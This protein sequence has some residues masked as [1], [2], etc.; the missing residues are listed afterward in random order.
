MVKFITLVGHKG[1]IPA[2]FGDQPMPNPADFG[3][4]AEDDGSRNDPLLGQN[5]IANSH[6]EH[7]FDALRAAA[8]RI[9]LAAGEESTGEMVCRAAL[10][11]AERL[12]IA[13]VIF[14]SNHGGFLGGEYGMQGDRTR[15]PP[16]CARFSPTPAATTDR[17]RTGIGRRGRPRRHHHPDRA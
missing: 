6:H 9:V 7:D 3:L 12:G 10:A 8:T 15:S 1:P 5:M 17:R 14:P 13:P 4:P 2:D 16:S 11:V